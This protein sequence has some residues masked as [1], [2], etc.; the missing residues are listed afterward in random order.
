M[1]RHRR[2]HS[3]ARYAARLFQHAAAILVVEPNCL[4]CGKRKAEIFWAI[5]PMGG[6]HG[7][8]ARCA[9]IQ[10]DSNERL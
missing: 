10:E 7:F 6:I 9:E 8:C 1:W 5:D 3:A 4:V 2:L